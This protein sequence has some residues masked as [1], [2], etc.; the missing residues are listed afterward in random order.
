MPCPRPFSFYFFRDPAA[1]APVVRTADMAAL[2]SVL[3]TSSRSSSIVFLSD[4]DAVDGET[5][6]G[7][8]RFRRF[9]AQSDKICS[10]LAPR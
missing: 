3:I 8:V 2:C 10:A 9:D 4:L 1:S 7:A 6:R 5:R